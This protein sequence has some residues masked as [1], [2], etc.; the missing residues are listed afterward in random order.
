MAKRAPD[1]IKFYREDRAYGEFS[2]FSPHAVE[3]DGERWPTTEHYFQAMKFTQPEA[4]ARIREAATPGLAK[5]L[6]RRPGLRPDWESVKDAVMLTALRAKFTQHPK[7]R[8]LL[9]GTKDARLVEHTRRDF[10]WGDGG[11]GSGKNRLGQ[12]LMRVRDEL[13]DAESG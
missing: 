9:L 11:N 12:L 2:N 13:R 10:Y 8:R 3:L 7:L 1:V 6:G 4:R 5:Q